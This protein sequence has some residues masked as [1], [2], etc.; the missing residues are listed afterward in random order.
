MLDKT[1]CIFKSFLCQL[2]LHIYSIRMKLG[3]LVFDKNAPCNLCDE[4][5][6]TWH[7]LL[8]SCNYIKSLNL[9]KQ[10]GFPLINSDIDLF[11]LLLSD[12]NPSHIWFLFKV[13]KFQNKLRPKSCTLSAAMVCV[14]SFYYL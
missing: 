9:I 13:A 6:L 14:L 5:Q 11:N 10:P 12:P 7:H 1:P 4:N 3:T 8:Q 2:R